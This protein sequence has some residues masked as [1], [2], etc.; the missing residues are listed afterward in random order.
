MKYKNLEREQV[1]DEEL[2]RLEAEYRKQ[3]GEQ[4]EGEEEEVKTPLDTPEDLPA[5]TKEEETWKKRHSDLRSYSQKKL[6]ELQKEFDDFKR[7]AAKREKESKFPGNKAE[8]EEW[9]KE[10]PDLAR[11]IGTLMDQKAEEHVLSVSDEVQSVRRELEAERTAIARERAMTEI[12]K[13]HPDF[14]DLVKQEDFKEW[15]AAQPTERGPRIGQALYDA[16]YENETDAT[17]AIQAVNVYKSDLAK[18]APKKDTARE[19][20]ETVRRGHV[21]TPSSK[22]GKRT[23]TETEIES[24]KPWE[25]D[26]LEGEI[27]DARREGRIVYDISGAAR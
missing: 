4:G 9:V 2:A 11:V 20:A 21:T 6:N 8:A 14:L 26:K 27:E 12:L 17:S 15:V 19:A 25:Y 24:M 5:S 22:D 23:F 16:L 13:A 1:E 3:Y 18:K 10:Y 7:E